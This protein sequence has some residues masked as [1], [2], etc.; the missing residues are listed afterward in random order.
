MIQFNQNIIWTKFFADFKE[1][2]VTFRF[3]L[4]KASV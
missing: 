3:A 2:I 4:R 1:S